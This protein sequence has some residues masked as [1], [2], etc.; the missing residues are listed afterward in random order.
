M[1][2]Q[3]AVSHHPHERKL[4][5]LLALLIVLAITVKLLEKLMT[6]MS[7]IASAFV[8][9]EETVLRHRHVKQK[10]KATRADSHVK[11]CKR[12][13]AISKLW[14]VFLRLSSLHY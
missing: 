9:I 10:L 11:K 8:D 7:R 14:R 1:A 12:K 2:K 13:A 4:N 5:L 6:S 3:I